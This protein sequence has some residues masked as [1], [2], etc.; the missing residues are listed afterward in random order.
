LMYLDINCPFE[1]LHLVNSLTFSQIKA[2]VPP[3]YLKDIAVGVIQGIKW[4]QGWSTWPLGCL[5]ELATS[6]RGNLQAYLVQIKN[7]HRSNSIPPPLFNL[8]ELVNCIL[9]PRLWLCA[10]Q[11][12]RKV[13][14]F[15]KS[16]AVG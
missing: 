1:S 11:F 5:W 3:Q 8:A 13:Q 10:V 15:Q 9:F 14:V 7:L 2:S 4:K 16:R 12:S 6:L